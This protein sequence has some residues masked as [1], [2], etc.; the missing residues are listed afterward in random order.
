[1][2]I[3]ELSIIFPIYNEEE[4][5]KKSLHKITKL[6]KAFKSIK[7]EIILVNDGSTDKTHELINAFIESTKK[8]DKKKII[9]VYYIKNRGKG[10]GLKKGIQKAN[11]KWSLTCDIDFSVNP[12]E[13]QKW[14][15]LNYIKKEKNCYFGSRSLKTSDVNY[16]YHRYYLGNIFNFLV[17]VI[18]DLNIGDTQCGFKLYH[19]SYAKK[20]FSKLKEY[21]Y[22]HDVEIAV[23]LKRNLINII[24][25]PIKWI[26][27]DKSKLNIFYDGLKM[28]IKLLFIKLRY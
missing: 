25:L 1:M 2:I 28:I 16:S 11:K 14:V 10:Y 9:Y 24:E 6:F 20:I 27:R 4:R 26:H 23:L 13:V 22:S 5:L 3:K 15:K 18:F 12:I 8:K 17:S 19:R 7:I 21:D